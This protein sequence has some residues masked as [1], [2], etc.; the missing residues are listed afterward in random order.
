MVIVPDFSSDVCLVGGHGEDIAVGRERVLLRGC[1]ADVTANL[2]VKLNFADAADQLLPEPRVSVCGEG[3]TAAQTQCG[4]V[5]PAVGVAAAHVRTALDVAGDEVLAL[6]QVPAVLPQV[7]QAGVAAA[8]VPLARLLLPQRLARLGAEVGRHVVPRPAEL[9]LHVVA[10]A[11]AGGHGEQLTLAELR[12]EVEAATVTALQAGQLTLGEVGAGQRLGRGDAEQP[13]V[14]AAPPADIHAG[15]GRRQPQ[16]QQ[17]QAL[18]PHGRQRTA[19][20]GCWVCRSLQRRSA[21]RLAELPSPPTV[22]ASFAPPCAPG[23]AQC[24]AARRSTPARRRRTTDVGQFPRQ[25]HVV[26]QPLGVMTCDQG[27]RANIG[28][29][30]LTST[31]LINNAHAMHNLPANKDV[32]R[33]ERSSS[34][35]VCDPVS[36]SYDISVVGN[37][38]VGTYLVHPGHPLSVFR[39]MLIA[40]ALHFSG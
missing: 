37:R 16:Q 20:T 12:V 4:V 8:A 27:A 34:L 11:V 31:F 22:S 38:C 17:Q 29:P 18:W 9:L 36:H 5:L 26:P 23:P 24:C 14:L 10:V 21:P 25:L 2:Q 28:I 15:R 32:V 40:Y 6:L 7:A 3:L 13:P 35:A 39:Y 19:Q 1:D 30:T 33:M